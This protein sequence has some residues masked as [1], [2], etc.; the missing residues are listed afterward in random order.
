M[1]SLY[2]I[3]LFMVFFNVFCFAFAFFQVFPYEYGTGSATYGKINLTDEGTPAEVI[4]KDVSGQ[5]FGDILMIFFGDV[6]ALAILGGTIAASFI[7][8]SPAPFVV[9]F[10]AVVIMRTYQNSISVFEQLPINNYLMLAGLFG[11]AI[12]I[13]ITCAE[14]LTHGDT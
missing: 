14:V 11:M 9:G 2:V 4:F 1:K 10:I 5:N 13:L 8:H 6:T 7:A 3:I 12:L